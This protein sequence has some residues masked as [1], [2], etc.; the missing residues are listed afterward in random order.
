MQYQGFEWL[1]SHGII[2][3]IFNVSD[4]TMPEKKQ[5]LKLCFGCSCKAK[6][7]RSSK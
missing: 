5:P 6:S 4:Y 1:S 7:A 3:I 2:K